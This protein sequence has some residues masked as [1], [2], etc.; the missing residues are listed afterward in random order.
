MGVK[1]NV[2][3]E[4][5]THDAGV[6]LPKARVADKAPAGPD[7]R[8]HQKVS[9]SLQ[10]VAQCPN[11]S[12]ISQYGRSSLRL[13]WCVEWGGSSDI[14]AWVGQS[15]VSW[16]SKQSHMS[17]KRRGFF[18]DC[19]PWSSLQM[20][21]C[22]IRNSSLAEVVQDSISLVKNKNKQELWSSLAAP[23]VTTTIHN[24]NFHIKPF[25]VYHSLSCQSYGNSVVAKE[26]QSNCFSNAL[27][28]LTLKTLYLAGPQAPV[29][30]A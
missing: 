6:Q 1:T 26:L 22:I 18:L 16:R 3:S 15:S 20:L 13:P 24:L 4:V 11:I 17:Q 28:N 19:F 9:S 30:V 2:C 29:S 12:Q 10:L 8:L 27:E 14:C 5:R 7:L 21:M 25:V 23:S